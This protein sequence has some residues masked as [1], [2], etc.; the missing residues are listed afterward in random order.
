MGLLGL[1]LSTGGC[2]L[3]KVAYGLANRLVMT[4]LTDTFHLDDKQRLAMSHK[5]NEIHA[6]HRQQELPRYVALLDAFL[7]KLEDGLARGELEWLMR[8]STAGVE[9]FAART[10][11]DIATILDTLSP[12]QIAQAAGEMKK[13][14][15]ER[16]YAGWQA[17]VAR[18]RS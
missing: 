3:R 2:S 18:V 11:P 5:V 12:Q 15:R 8:E 6:W 14:E 13:S 9:R 1:L 10:A 16:L 4:R 17:A 7:P